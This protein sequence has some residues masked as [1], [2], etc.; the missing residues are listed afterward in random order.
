M[1]RHALGK[2]EGQQL[3]RLLRIAPLTDASLA[4]HLEAGDGDAA[5]GELVGVL[6][7][8]RDPGL[9]RRDS[10]ERLAQLLD[11]EAL[12]AR[13]LGR[14]LESLDVGERPLSGL[15]GLLAER[16]ASRTR[17]AE[18]APVASGER[19][20]GVLGRGNAGEEDFLL[21]REELG[22]LEVVVAAAARA[23]RLRYAEAYRLELLV[24]LRLGR[25]EPLDRAET[26]DL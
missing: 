13:R 17:R 3:G 18:A 5:V 1:R 16:R 23:S 24:D 8:G 2:D 12:Y 14:R 22:E 6:V 10:R 7:D 20:L 11:A 25:A 26:V 21:P 19:C 15:E 9:H 4:D